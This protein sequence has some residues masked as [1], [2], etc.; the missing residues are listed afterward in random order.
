[1]RHRPTEIKAVVKLLDQ[2]HDDVEALAVAV[3]DELVECKWSRGGY[4]V[5][6]KDPALPIPLMYGPYNTITQAR[7]DIGKRIV[8]TSDEARGYIHHVTN[9]DAREEPS[10]EVVA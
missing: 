8:G 2:E 1:M 3:L 6:L 7:R 4:V 9:L 5:V 10:P